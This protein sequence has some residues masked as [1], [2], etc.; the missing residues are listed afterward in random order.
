MANNIRRADIYLGVND[1]PFVLPAAVI[2]QAAEENR[3]ILGLEGIVRGRTIE[4]RRFQFVFPLK[5]AMETYMNREVIVNITRNM[6]QHIQMDYNEELGARLEFV[7]VR[8]NWD[9]SHP[10][11]F[12][13]NFQFQLGVN[14]LLKGPRDGD[15]DD[16]SGGDN[17][18]V[19]EINEEAAQGDEGEAEADPEE[20][21]YERNIEMQEEEADD[22]E[23]W[24]G[25]GKRTMFTDEVCDE[26]DYYPY[27]VRKIGTSDYEIGIK[28][29]AWLT[30]G[31]VNAS[32]FLQ[33]E[34]SGTQT[35]KRKRFPSS[36]GDNDDSENE[37]GGPS[38]DSTVRRLKE[39]NH[40]YLMD[41]ICL[42]ET[43][44][45]DDYFRDVGAQL[46]FLSYVTVPPNGSSGG[47]VV[48]WKSNVHLS[49]I[50]SSPNL[51]DCKVGRINENPFYFSFVYGDPN[52][53]LRHH[54]WEHLQRV[55][56]GRQ[57][58]AWFAL[59]DFNDIRGNH[60]KEGGRVKPEASFINFKI[61]MRICDFMDIRIIG[62]RF[63]W[64]GQRGLYHVKSCLDRSSCQILRKSICFFTN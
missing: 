55:S 39:I 35:T 19:E 46:G 23:L 44:Q 22:E 9:V 7:R 37:M 8:I 62:D 52:P 58:Q 36:A 25:A 26:D 2:Q 41:I 28:R 5:E 49:V 50:S 63:S 60:E 42:S 18:D 20:E 24:S 51:V 31:N 53:A 48:F 4:G 6:G 1:A 15:E 16:D 57:H 12:Q 61:M 64:V 10:L 32:K 30:D 54:T 21:A 17:D 40:K 13:R 43:K 27:P 33:G 38:I 29:K 11:K 34:S 3:F 45:Q 14:T 56:L 47:L 59:G